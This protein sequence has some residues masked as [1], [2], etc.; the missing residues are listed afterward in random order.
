VNFYKNNIL[1]FF[2]RKIIMP[3]LILSTAAG[4]YSQEISNFSKKS[5]SYYLHLKSG[6]FQKAMLPRE[7]FLLD[8]AKNITEELKTR[9]SHGLSDGLVNIDATVSPGKKVVENYIDELQGTVSLL[10]EISSLE[11]K[12]RQK[13]NFK[14]LD[15][16]SK[17]RERVKNI[18]RGSIN[19]VKIQEASKSET[20]QKAG[21]QIGNGNV[22]KVSQADAVFGI[23]RPNPADIFEEWKYN[24]ILEYKTRLSRWEFLRV[25]LMESATQTE[26]DR[27]FRRAL[28]SA[29]EHYQ[30]GDL[31]TARIEFGD[32]LKTYTHI[33]ILDDVL[34]FS[35]EAAYGRNFFDEAIQKYTLVVTLYPNS[36]YAPKAFVKLIFIYS[37]YGN[38][39]KIDKYYD[40]LIP[41][42][43]KLD[44]ERISVVSYLSGYSLF[45]VGQY[46]KIFKYLRN[47]PEG[48]TYYYPSLYLEATCYANLGQTERAI[49]IFNKLINEENRGG[50]DVILGQIKNNSLL[51]MGLIYYDQGNDELAVSYLDRVKK[52][53]SHYDL[54]VLGKAWSEYRAGKPGEALRDVETL[55]KTSMVSNYAYEA[56]VLAASVKDLLGYSEE[57]MQDMKD[58]YQIGT[59]AGKVLNPAGSKG[60]ISEKSL[61]VSP[62]EQQQQR[63]LKEVSKIRSFL[64][65]A[66]S[67]QDRGASEDQNAR[68]KRQGGDVQNLLSKIG[69]LDRL[70][71][72]AR[73]NHDS[74]LLGEVR[75]LRSGLIKAVQDQTERFA[76]ESGGAGNR[77]IV[78]RIGL[79]EYLRYTF[80]ALI[81]EMM[82]EKKKTI[83]NI[84]GAG[85]ILNRAK[86]EDKFSI[87]IR[88]EI[89]KEELEDYYRRLNQYEVWLK[90]NFPKEE[91]VEIDKWAS[92]SGY[93]ISNIN[94]MRIKEYDNRIADIA[95]VIDN[96]DGIFIAKRKDLDNRI[97]GLLSDVQKIEEQMQIESLKRQKS[98][99]DKFFKNEYFIKQKRESAAGK[100]KEK[101]DEPRVKKE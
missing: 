44:P 31:K 77:S 47:V 90:E 22:G 27:M 75:S 99:K 51:K 49:G 88:A 30:A 53:Y 23:S 94:F 72:L 100:L 46:E 25:K 13:V 43:D 66:V 71:E 7:R 50:K 76:N 85:E 38:F 34:Y 17:L 54:T 60:D 67:W 89:K 15:A 62:K 45:K 16:L 12:A 5:G 70:E 8:I 32:I 40:Q 52:N 91:N 81:S 28:R 29:L 84:K 1:L 21:K 19:A 10:D 14:V 83:R 61:N 2:T 92:F 63:L 69:E 37:I 41:I 6:E 3:G 74:R 97:Q 64:H 93:G 98:E 11:R 33:P 80:Q 39:N 26:Y 4:L 95:Q 79:N 18:V 57:A 78:S 36:E 101:P 68:N 48:T 87:F 24:R 42:M 82:R 96:I 73:N 86:E 58:A 56:K 20:A 35:G 9:Q 65:G 55:L 59:L